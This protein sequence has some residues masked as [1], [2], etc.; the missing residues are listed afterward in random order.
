MAKDV[1]EQQQPKEYDAAQ[2]KKWPAITGYGAY[3]NIMP[4]IVNG[5]QWMTTIEHRAQIV[6]DIV[7]TCDSLN[8]TGK[9]APKITTTSTTLAAGISVPT[10]REQLLAVSA[11]NLKARLIDP[12]YISLADAGL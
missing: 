7:A 5:K 1:Q 8:R 11:T 12:G 6:H 2:A 10:V 4:N 3:K 9:L